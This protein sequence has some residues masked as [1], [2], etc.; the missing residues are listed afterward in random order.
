MKKQSKNFHPDPMNDSQ[1]FLKAALD[2][3]S[4]H[5]AILDSQGTI[6]SVNRSWREFAMKNGL[7]MQDAG[8]GA[9]YLL[10]CESATGIGSEK[11]YEAAAGIRKVI[12]GK[13]NDFY[14]EYTCHSPKI[15]RW[16][17]LR[18]T[19]FAGPT[20]TSVVLSHENITGR[21]LVEETRVAN[22]TQYRTIF[23]NAADSIFLMD[24]D[25]FVDCNTSTL[26]I[27]ACTR[28]QILNETPYKFSPTQ[29]PDGRDSREKALEYIQAALDGKPQLFEWTHTRADGTPFDAEVRLNRVDLYGRAHI[30]ASV[31]DI[32]ERKKAELALRSANQQLKARIAEIEALQAQLRDQ[33]TKDFL[34]D[35]YNRR[36]LEEALQRELAQA[37]RRTSNL[38]VVIMDIDHFKKINDSYGHHAGDIVLKDFVE[39]LRHSIRSGDTL[40]RYGGD[41]FVVLMPD[42][43]VQDALSR[44]TAWQASF[45]KRDF[46][47]Q[48]K[49]I[50]LKLSIGIATYP[51]HASSAE[52]LL[53]AADQALY[54]SKENHNGVTVSLRGP[55]RRLNS[56]LKNEKER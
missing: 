24:G 12:D 37:D 55:T 33:A 4:A 53:H 9:N 44:V 16:F 51:Y 49:S 30:L 19:R 1:L 11:A 31:R 40:C 5:I 41:E 39:F 45:S 26:K 2:A 18:V 43:G 54:Q 21:K 52:G 17:A 27:F 13:Q 7:K 47:L 46:K 36:Y 34:T 25:R 23:E 8:V 22:V 3:L 14:L 10:I 50:K 38:S 6:L 42:A 35:A 20:G 32:S 28:R 48:E 56:R 29:Q 15:K